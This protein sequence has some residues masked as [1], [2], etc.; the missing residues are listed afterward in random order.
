MQLLLLKDVGKLGH[1]GDVVDVSVGYA[2]NYLIPQKLATDP[3]EENIA[4]IEEEKKRAAA[5][6]AR[7]LKE[8]ETLAEQMADVTATV[9]TLDLI[10]P[11]IMSKKIAEGAGGLVLDV[12]TGCGA[13]MREKKESIALAESLVEIGMKLNME[14]FAYITDMNQPLGRAIGNG[15]EVIQ[16]T[17]E[18]MG[19][20]GYPP[21]LLASHGVNVMV[22]GGLG[23][24]AIMMFEELGIMV[25]V[26]ASGTVKDAI[27]MWQDGRL[28]AATDENACRQHAFRGEGMGDGHG[29]NHGQCGDK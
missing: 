28:Q 4:A 5:E 22:C 7:R 13:F 8:F 24:R 1:V 27:Q 21:D 11:S 19:G 25:Y 29:H 20:S 10:A 26:G 14:V 12:K 15:V 9:D 6:R 17:S 2:R 18:H 3:T 16:N 23:R